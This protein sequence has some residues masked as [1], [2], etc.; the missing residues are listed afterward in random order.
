MFLLRATSCTRLISDLT[1]SLSSTDRQPKN[2]HSCYYKT[3]T[4]D[5]MMISKYACVPVF[6]F[7][8]LKISQQYKIIKPRFELIQKYIL[9]VCPSMESLL[10]VPSDSAGLS[11]FFSPSF[12][13]GSLRRMWRAFLAAS[14]L[15][16]WRVG[17]SPMNSL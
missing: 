17:P 2:S 11:I 13:T 12:G 10:D 15:A 6:I 4:Q 9:S 14:C 8:L 5:L 1:T 3:Q 7:F 16:S